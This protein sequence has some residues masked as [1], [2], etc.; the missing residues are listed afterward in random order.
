MDVSTAL[1]A[2]PQP[3]ELVQASQGSLHHPAVHSQPAAVFRACYRRARDGA[4]WR[5]RNSWRCRRE[6]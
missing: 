6:S 5:L 3:A 4:M 2:Y 1:V